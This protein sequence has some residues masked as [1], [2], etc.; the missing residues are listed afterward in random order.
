M[1]L[2]IVLRNKL[3]LTQ[4]TF[5]SLRGSAVNKA[6]FVIVRSLSIQQKQHLSGDDVCFE[7]GISITQIH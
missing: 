1:L 3:R 6:L 5:A 2:K 4:M 7:G